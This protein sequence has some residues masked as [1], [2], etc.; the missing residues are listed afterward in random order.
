MST[1]RLTHLRVNRLERPLAVGD[2]S[3]RFGWRL[4]SEEYDHR[5]VA[6]RIRVETAA[7]HPAWDSGEVRSDVSQAIAFGQGGSEALALEPETAYRW[8]VEIED[9]RGRLLGAESTF[10]T[11]FFGTTVDAWRGARWIGADRPP[12]D[13][14][15]LVVYRIRGRLTVPEGSSGASLVLGADDFRLGNDL[16]NEFRIRGANHVRFE[17]DVAD[18]A[19]PA[20]RIHRRGY[21]PGEADETLLTTVDDSRSTNIGVLLPPERAHLENAIELVC[22]SSTFHVLINGVELVADGSPEFQVN[23]RGLDDVASFPNLCSIGFEAA[24]GQTFAVRGYEVLTYREPQ[25]AL[26]DERD[27]G[28]FE[29]LP[30]VTVDGGTI[31]VDGG[32]DGL[33]AAV[34]PSRDSL[35]V[36]RRTVVTRPGWRNARASIT[37]RGVYELRVNGV[38]VG[39]D[40][41][42]PGSSDY[43]HTIDYSVYDLTDL[44]RD[45]EN[46]ITAALAPGWWA[47]MVS[48]QET[49]T[50]FY[51]DRPALLCH[52]RIDNEDGATDFVVSKPGEWEVS[53]SGPVRSGSFF[54]GERYDARLEANLDE[55]ARGWVPAT[56]IPPLERNARPALV[57]KVDRPVQAYE[58][59]PARLIGEVRPGSDSWLYDLGVNMVGVPRITLEG[60]AGQEIVIRTAEVLYPALPEYVERDV[61]GL[62][63]TENLREALSTDVYICRDGAQTYTPRF[64][65][66]GFQ[67]LEISGTG[68]PLP[69]TAVTGVV[70]SS[71]DEVTGTLETS[72]PLVDRLMANITRSQLGNFLSIPTDCPQRNERMGWT[73]A[74]TEF[75]RTASFTADVSTFTERWLSVL[76]DSQVTDEL[77]VG[78]SD[79][80]GFY[81]VDTADVGNADTGGRKPFG[82][83]YVVGMYPSYAPSYDAAL[84]WGTPWSSAGVL[85]PYDLYR[86]YGSTVVIE[87]SFD[88]MLAYLEAMATLRLPGSE[89]LSVDGGIC[90]DWLSLDKPPS[91][92]T[93]VAIYVF[94]L[95]AFGEMAAAIGRTDVAEDYARE[96]ALARQEWNDRFIDSATGTLRGDA[97]APISQSST[98]IALFYGL[99]FDEFV[100]TVFASLCEKVVAGHDGVAFGITTGMFT[101][102]MITHVLSDHG[103]SD[104]AFGM[105]ENTAFPSWL[106]PVTQGATSTWERWNSYTAE[107][108]FGG[109]NAMN[110]FNH[111][112]LGAVGA[113]LL[114]R[115]GGIDRNPARVG[116]QHFVFHPVPAGRLQ[117]ARATVVT[118]HGRVESDWSWDAARTVWTCLLRVPANTTATVDLEW[119]GGKAFDLGSG[120]WSLVFDDGAVHVDRAASAALVR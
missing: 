81:D 107:E 9:D 97:S 117:S 7:G 41:F 54:Q 77:L 20:L 47:D 102:P 82:G 78:R 105:L 70:L 110:S 36:L 72:N 71:I 44:L 10:E 12:L 64:T 40:W 8:R 61:D 50:G 4:E 57:A 88:S 27:H 49:N 73:E 24:P 116:M 96:Y 62:P 66:H 48:F 119:A 31:R 113:W 108:G 17:I 115:V 74:V 93:D 109:N 35:P 112:S 21:A 23:P 118:D 120:A 13:A 6:Y 79:M 103:R 76:R 92:Y 56:S 60:R 111:F 83:E 86:H 29:G 58:T 106:Y 100:P 94:L 46:T 42:N 91:D 28:V 43:R 67:Y 98:T 3:P 1:P 68:G 55:D 85:V 95:R 37:A 101:T 90:G 22:E 18:P 33:L 32:A 2:G 63:M 38:R 65:F 87:E 99:P 104:L 84:S 15:S 26:F 89:H 25:T 34:D 51:G 30:G 11:A 114:N 39:E 5:Q 14:A 45:G 69:D 80:T 75:A 59:L 53:V 19:R 16:F 52:L